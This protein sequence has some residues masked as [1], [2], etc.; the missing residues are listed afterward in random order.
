VIDARAI[1]DRLFPPVRRRM[2]RRTPAGVDLE[3]ASQRHPGGK[4]G[5]RARGSYSPPP[6]FLPPFRPSGK[7]FTAEN[8]GG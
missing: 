8:F 7:K 6:L 3:T 1:A 5:D 4:I 2:H